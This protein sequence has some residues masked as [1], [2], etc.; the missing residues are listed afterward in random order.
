LSQEEDKE[1]KI[2]I[3]SNVSEND[4]DC[5]NL[6]NESISFSPPHSKHLKKKRKRKKVKNDEKSINDELAMINKW[7]GTKISKMNE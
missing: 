4:N 3:L 2:G 6:K 1:K 5:E 7:K